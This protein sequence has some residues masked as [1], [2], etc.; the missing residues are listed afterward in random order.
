MWE[1]MKRL[2][3]LLCIHPVQC[4]VLKLVAG[5][6]V[7]Y[8]WWWTPCGTLIHYT[9]DDTVCA[10]IPLYGT[11][12]KLALLY[13]DSKYTVHYWC[14]AMTHEASNRRCSIGLSITTLRIWRRKGK[15]LSQPD[16]DVTHRSEVIRE[17][18][19]LTRDYVCVCLSQFWNVLE[20]RLVW[21]VA[22]IKLQTNVVWTCSN[23]STDWRLT[24]IYNGSPI[25]CSH[26]DKPA[27]HHLLVYFFRRKSN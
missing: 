12:I 21:L 2:T 9:F 11:I 23:L 27:Q 3:V 17:A 15:A 24:C 18:N 1:V 6:V 14:M 20:V 7:L 25:S 19:S 4:D 26:L 22:Q 5:S 16:V 13:N 8:E 10:M